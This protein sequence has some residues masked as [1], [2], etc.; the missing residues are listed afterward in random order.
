MNFFKHCRANRFLIVSLFCFAP[1]VAHAAGLFLAPRGVRPL[2]RGGSY[3][4]GAD[5]VNALSYNPAGLAESKTGVL[6]DLGLPLYTTDYTRQV[7]NT[8]APMQTVQGKGMG[9]PIPTLGATFGLEQVPDLRFGISIA[10][11]YPQLQQWPDSATSPQ[12]YAIGNY[13]GTAI[14]KIATGAAYRFSDYLSIGAAFQLLTGNFA[15]ETTASGC[16]GGMCTQPEN[17]DYDMRIQMAAKNIWVPGFHAGVQVRPA[18]WVRLGL[19]WETGYT[20]DHGADFRIRLPNAPAYAGA[21][22]SSDTIK[23]HIKMRLPQVVRG[24]VE[25]R[26][27]SMARVES[28]VVWEQWSVHDKININLGNAQINNLTAL[29]TYGVSPMAIHRGFKDTWSLRLGGEVAPPLPNGLPL[30]FRAG[31]MYEPSAIPTA[32]LTAMTVDLDKYLGA[33]GAAYTLGRFQFE[34]TY[35]HIFMTGRTVTNS[36]IRQTNPTR[37][38]WADTT[39]IGNG[40]YSASANVLGMGLSIAL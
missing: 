24:G 28:S 33:L 38:G 3:V 9:I 32:N 31:F 34:L 39:P 18:P 11:D 1:S 21:S 26:I 10:A 15:S 14:T 2:A 7:Y 23:G 37:P 13:N 4:A 40:K 29:G 6:I 20:I 22:M 8:S 19:A 17:P 35:A 30:V 16:D 25:F 12:R 36:A 27:G 5:D